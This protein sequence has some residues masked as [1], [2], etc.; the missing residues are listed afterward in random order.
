MTQG[1]PAVVEAV[2]SVERLSKWQSKLA[3]V[4]AVIVLALSFATFAI[5]VSL[6]LGNQ[7]LIKARTAA[8]A[9][10]RAAV[11]GLVDK[12]DTLINEV[13][14]LRV[15]LNEE[16]PPLPATTPPPAGH[17]ESLG[18]PDRPHARTQAA[19]IAP[20]T[21]SPSTPQPAPPP[22]SNDDERDTQAATAAPRTRAPS[23][24]TPSPEPTSDPIDDLVCGL[25]GQCEP[26]KP[27]ALVE[28]AGDSV[29][30]EGGT[31]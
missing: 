1:P 23:T 30:R 28:L 21:P 9:R 5:V 22:R 16:I 13:H 26:V 24:P 29:V 7:R 8:E 15:E 19:P 4:I 14:S 20:T 6:T 12:I 17:D 25:L 2:A 11:A 31:R 18:S 27:P 3:V 10:G